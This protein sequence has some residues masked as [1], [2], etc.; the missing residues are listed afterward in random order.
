[1]ALGPITQCIVMALS[2][3]TYLSEVQ[4]GRAVIYETFGGPEVLELRDVPE[5]HPEPGQ[6]R[7]RVTAAGLNPM[8]G[9]I[10]FFGGDLAARF[11]SVCRPASD[12]LRRCDRRDRRQRRRLCGG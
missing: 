6:V 11:G 7:V 9:G 5:P 8:D 4:L 3:I 1:M 10:V 12:R 2:L